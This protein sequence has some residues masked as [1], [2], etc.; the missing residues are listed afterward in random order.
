MLPNT[1]KLERRFGGRLP[2]DRQLMVQLVKFVVDLRAELIRQGDDRRNPAVRRRCQGN[3][4][5]GLGGVEAKVLV[6]EDFDRGERLPGVLHAGRYLARGDEPLHAVGDGIDGAE[7]PGGDLDGLVRVDGV[8]ERVGQRPETLKPVAYGAGRTRTADA[9]NA[10]P[11]LV[12]RKEV[13]GVD[14]FVD[15]PYGT[16]DELGQKLRAAAG[17]GLEPTMIT[18]RGLKVWPDG[19]PE[20]F[21]SDNFRCRFLAATGT[22][23]LTP[24]DIIALLERVTATGLVFGKIETLAIYDGEKG[25]TLGQGE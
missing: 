20:T 19:F 7:G 25:Y 9:K 13:V 23:S 16:P 15:W 10:P 8:V 18:S 21:T 22:P 1:A 11:P 2:G 5:P 14:V 6:D 3:L 4:D 17:G 24:K 12:K